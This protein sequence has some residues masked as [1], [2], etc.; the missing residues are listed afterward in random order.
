M[1]M[2]QKMLANT[3]K[4]LTIICS[5]AVI[6]IFWIGSAWAETPYE[7]DWSA[8]RIDWTDVDLLDLK[9]AAEIALVNNPSLAA[10]EARVRQATER[11]Q[12]ARARYWPSLDATFA[13]ARI[14]Y[15]ENNP[16]PVPFGDD[17]EDRFQADL[18]ATWVL[19][20]GFARKFA[21]AS[22]HYGKSQSEASSDEAKRLILSAVASA[23]FAA[24]LAL[25]NIVIAEANQAF[26]Q[27]QLVDAEARYRVGTGALS[28]VLNFKIRVNEAKTSLINSE[29]VF[30]ETMYGLAALLGAPQSCFPEK[31]KLA[32]LKEETPEEMEKPDADALARLALVYR[33]DLKETRFALNQSE[34]QIKIAQSRFY[35]SISLAAAIDGDRTETAGFEND[36][37]GN[38]VGFNLTYNLFAGGLDRAKVKEARARTQELEKN[39]QDLELQVNSEV[40]ISSTQ[41]YTTQRQLVLQRTNAELNQQ[42]RD[43]VE[44]EYAAGQ[45]SLVRLNE[46][47]RD[48]TTAQG[49]LALAL[50]SLRQAWFNLE[51]DTGRILQILSKEL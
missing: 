30:N 28:D 22:A 16:N 13:G 34:A 42:N 40:R 43:L 38:T 26:N 3:L 51:T 6:L 44:K 10:A 20:D 4:R 19:F 31:M 9:K 11:L 45:V 14:S 12:Q 2:N 50:A 24:Q 41:V 35:P 5:F 17:P 47:Q 8:Q 27:R 23:Y 29:R 33:P 32:R 46:A 49:R 39:L 15:A 7:K 48:L 1:G 18:T 36:D 37:F 25:E 21:N